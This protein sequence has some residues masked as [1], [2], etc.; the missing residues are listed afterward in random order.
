[1]KLLKTRSRATYFASL[2]LTAQL[3]LHSSENA[4]VHPRSA[5]HDS[6]S[7]FSSD[8]GILGVYA[9]LSPA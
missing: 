1:M 5:F 2:L 9:R 7:E 3:N 8:R 4:L 6:I